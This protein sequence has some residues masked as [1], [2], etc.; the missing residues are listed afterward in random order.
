MRVNDCIQE[1]GVGFLFAPS[2]HPAFRVIAPVRRKLAEQGM[3]TVFN[4]LGPLLNPAQ[5]AA[6]LTGVFSPLILEK[7]GIALRKLA[8]KRPRVFYG[9][10]NSET[11]MDQISL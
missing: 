7:Y 3:A 2:Y 6:Q 11:G 1:T 9:Q 10:V 8:R 5:P 4:L